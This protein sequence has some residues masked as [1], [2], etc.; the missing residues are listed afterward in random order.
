MSDA[1]QV[2]AVMRELAAQR[3]G[4]SKPVRLAR[5]LALRAA[6]LPDSERVRLL[7]ALALAGRN[8]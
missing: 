3:W 5:E 6:E 7:N 8:E 1:A 4:A 2:S